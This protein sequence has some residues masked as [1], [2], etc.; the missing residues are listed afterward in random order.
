MSSNIDGYIPFIGIVVILGA[1]I[2]FTMLACE[3]YMKVRPYID[4]FAGWD[5]LLILIGVPWPCIRVIKK[6]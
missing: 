6:L 2:I 5:V 1:P 3:L 4:Y